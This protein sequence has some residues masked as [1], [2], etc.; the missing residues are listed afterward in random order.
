MNKE[1]HYLM[2]QKQLNRYVTISRLIDGQISTGEAVSS[3]G[4]CKR[5]ILRLKKGVKEKGA[6]FL[7]HQNKGR[8]P[9]HAIGDILAEKIIALRRSHPYQDANF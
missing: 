2:S 7:V 8:K 5:Q 3:L 6:N 4:L 9:H 1:V